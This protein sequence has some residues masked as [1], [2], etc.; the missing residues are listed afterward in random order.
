[1]TFRPGTRYRLV[2]RIPG[3]ERYDREH[4]LTY[5]GF[6]ND[7]AG[8]RI[9]GW[10]A[11]P[12]AGT[13]EFPEGYIKSAVEVP[14]GTPHYMNRRAIEAPPSPPVN[15]GSY[16]IHVDE[17]T[18]AVFPG[19]ARVTVTKI[20][21]PESCARFGVEIDNPDRVYIPRQ[22]ANDPSFYTDGE[23]SRDFVAACA[24]AAAWAVMIHEANV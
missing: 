16:D 23:D 15:D 2:T 19:F 12:I 20:V 10:S 11:R 22:I 17:M 18:V 5:L 21:G 9:H 7:G 1:M 24:V 13:Q 14:P 6:H 3:V 4:V 8:R